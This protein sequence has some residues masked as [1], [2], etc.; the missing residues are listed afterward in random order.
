MDPFTL[1]SEI[2]GLA[3]RGIDVAGKLKISERTHLVMPYHKLEDQCSELAAG[4]VA[5]IGTTS[6]GIGPAYAEKMKRSTAF[7]FVDL[8]CD[9]AFPERF[10]RV[11]TDR[12][13]AMVARYGDAADLDVDALANDLVSARDRLKPPVAAPAN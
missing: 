10:R 12:K 13:T 7:R 5:K 2:D 1:L 3:E 8:A 11:A 6:R 4:D 9:P